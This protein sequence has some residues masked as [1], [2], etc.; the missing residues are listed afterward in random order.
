MLTEADRVSERLTAR[1]TL[2]RTTTAAVC[3]TPV[4]LHK[5]V[6]K[7]KSDCGLETCYYRQKEP[8]IS[9]ANYTEK[10]ALR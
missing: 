4:D 6:H 9:K 1:I 2:V 10:T 7:Y 3:P 8:Q 5:Y